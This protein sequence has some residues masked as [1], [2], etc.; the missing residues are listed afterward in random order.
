MAITITQQPPTISFA[1]SPMVYSVSSNNSGNAGFKYVADVFIW[2]GASGSV[3]VSYT[4]RL[5][6]RKESV[7]N[8]YGY[9]DVSNIVS[10]YLSQTNIDHAAGTA[11]DNEQTVCNVVV[12]FREYTT[13]GGIGAV[14]ATS[15]TIQA[16]DGYTEFVDGVND[17]TTTG[18]MTSG[19]SQQYIQLEQAMTIG[20][21][22][23]LVNG[24]RVEYS[25]GQAAV[26]DVA[27]FGAVNSTDSTDK[28]WFLPAGVALSLIHI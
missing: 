15:N 20:I 5:I 13:A 12:K 18:V 26:V 17:T 23:S 16:Y 22:P 11:T 19:S 14:S 25:D 2:F 24:M 10:S 3:P 7:S 28:L 4:Y 27:D 6:K 9:F 21:V 1:G 8:L